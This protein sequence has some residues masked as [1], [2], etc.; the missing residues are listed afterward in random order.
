[1]HDDAPEVELNL[2]AIHDEQAVEL[3]A[4]VYSPGLHPVQLD[5]PEVT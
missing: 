3:G 1:M 5:E 2:P 4:P